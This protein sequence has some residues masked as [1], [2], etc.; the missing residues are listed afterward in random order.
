MPPK[1]VLEAIEAELR[2]PS[3]DARPIRAASVR[4]WM[5]ATDPEVRGAAYQLLTEAGCFRRI[6]PRLD[7]DEVF[8]WLLR[9]YEWCLTTNPQ[10]ERPDSR[11]SAAT[12]MLLWFVEM[13]DEGVGR[14]YLER[15]S[16]LVARLYKAGAPDLQRSLVDSFLEHAFERDDIREFFDPWKAD[17]QLRVAHEE[18][19]RW[20]QGGGRMLPVKPGKGRK[21]TPRKP[22]RD[23]TTNTRTARGGS[24]TKPL[25][26]QHG[27]GASGQ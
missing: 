9:Y 14:S 22:S 18:A 26:G 24:Q 12:D 23:E 3:E 19:A 2:R 21:P 6:T 20:H 13:W 25:R 8:D 4:H 11:F 10:G 27:S 5:E 17:P 16:D 7:P 15:I 1:T